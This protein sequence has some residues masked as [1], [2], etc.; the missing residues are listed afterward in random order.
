[1]F[2]FI[3]DL[4]SD[5]ADLFGGAADKIGGLWGG[6]QAGGV[7]GLAA[8]IFGGSEDDPWGILDS[9]VFGHIA[10]AVGTE[11]LRDDP[12]KQAKEMEKARL[13]AI[14][15]YSYGLPA[16]PQAGAGGGGYHT[17]APRGLPPPTAPTAAKYMPGGR[18]V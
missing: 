8:K 3:G 9:P 10:G 16:T 15:E 4:I 5:A 11:L 7:L 14:R 1:M 18:L 17:P 12:V 13:Q 2:D 6:P